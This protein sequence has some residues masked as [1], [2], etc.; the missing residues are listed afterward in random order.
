MFFPWL[1]TVSSD[2]YLRYYGFV[3]SVR[4]YVSFNVFGTYIFGYDK[5]FLKFLSLVDLVSSEV[6]VLR[7]LHI[8]RL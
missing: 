3:D 8:C 6:V 7:C 2:R 1:I 5:P 4:D